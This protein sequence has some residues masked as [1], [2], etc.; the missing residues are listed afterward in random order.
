MHL[1]SS[2]FAVTCVIAA[3]ASGP[4]IA[5]TQTFDLHWEAL[6]DS[7]DF[8]TA[9]LDVDIAV[10]EDTAVNGSFFGGSGPASNFPGEDCDDGP[11]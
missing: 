8:A 2:I 1:S 7:D 3:F 4:L 9:S 5:A 10:F 6:D 11:S